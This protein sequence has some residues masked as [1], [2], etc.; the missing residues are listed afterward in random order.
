MRLLAAFSGGKP[1]RGEDRIRG[2]LLGL[3]IDPVLHSGKAL[4]GLMDVVA[5]G[6]VG[7]SFEQLL[8]TL[9]LVQHLRGSCVS[10]AGRAAWRSHRRQNFFDVLHPC[11]LPHGIRASTLNLSLTS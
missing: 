2:G 8:E 1:Q 10:I 6:N 4:G 7:K 11:A 9:A 5:I 3:A